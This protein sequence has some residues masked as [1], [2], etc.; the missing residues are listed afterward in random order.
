LLEEGSFEIGGL[1]KVNIN[2]RVKRACKRTVKVGLT[3]LVDE[4]ADSEADASEAALLTSST[5]SAREAA[6]A[7]KTAE[8]KWKRIANGSS[9]T[10]SGNCC[11]V[12]EKETR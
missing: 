10:N 12:V 1:M 11:Q 9:L 6:K 7:I 5:A 3:M 2:R 8:A 4:A